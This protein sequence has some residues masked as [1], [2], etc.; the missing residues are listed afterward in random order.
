[1]EGDTAVAA[2]GS[3]DAELELPVRNL[4]D[5][6][7]GVR[8]GQ[9]H[10]DVQVLL[11]ELAEQEWHHRAAG[12]GRGPELER[13]GDRALVVGLELFE[14]MLLERKQ[15][16]R[17]RVEHAP[18]LGRFHTAPGA[19]EQLAP[20]PLLERADLQADR[21]LSHPEALSV[22]FSELA[23]ASPTRPRDA[24]LRVL[25]VFLSAFFLLVTAPVTIPIALVVLL[26]SGRPLF[27]R[28]E[29]V[30]RGGRVFAMLK[31][32]TLS[33][34]AE[35]RLGPFLGEELVRRTR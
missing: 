7:L 22:R 17:R 26:T 23:Q 25:D 12:A 3:D 8:H 11:V 19:V 2:S 4:V 33:A 29:R 31:F 27:Y 24:A 35:D 10:A 16:L 28:G 20:E 30:G 9:P 6:R 14:E 18:G 21:R 1:F 34:S 13:A 5:E 15:P 32:R